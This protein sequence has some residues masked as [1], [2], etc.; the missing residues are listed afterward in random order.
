MYA[1][2]VPTG[3]LTQLTDRSEGVLFGRL[4]PDGR[5]VYYLDDEQ[6]NEIG[7]HVRVSFEGSE[8]QDVTPDMPPYSSFGLAISQA[9]NLLGFTR[10]DPDG[11]KTYCMDLE[12]DGQLGAP[13]LLYQSKQQGKN[14]S[15]VA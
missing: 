4:S 8:P 3:K 1:W 9:S 10:A 12:P 5:H 13:R 14:Q 15:T 6:G 11:F 2:H 7:H